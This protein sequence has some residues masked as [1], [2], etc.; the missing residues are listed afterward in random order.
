MY[1][2]VSV[3]TVRARH[4]VQKTSASPEHPHGRDRHCGMMPLAPKDA[5]ERGDDH[6]CLLFCVALRR[7]RAMPVPAWAIVWPSAAAHADLS[8]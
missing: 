7:A 3:P 6:G 8:A 4:G 5:H 1:Y 2:K